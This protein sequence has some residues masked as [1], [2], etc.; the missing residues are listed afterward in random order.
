[1]SLYQAIVAAGVRPS[2]AARLARAIADAVAE[3]QSS[4]FAAVRPSSGFST[5]GGSNDFALHASAP[6]SRYNPNNGQVAPGPAALGV[7]GVAVF[8]GDVVTLGKQYTRGI[9]TKGDMQATGKLS[10]PAVRTAFVSVLNAATFSSQAATI[11]TPIVAQGGLACDGS[12]SFGNNVEFNGRVSVRGD[13]DWNGPRVPGDVSVVRALHWDAA[14]NALYIHRGPIG[15]LNDYGTDHV[16]SVPL[17]TPGPPVVKVGSCT[18]IP[19]LSVDKSG[20]V[21]DLDAATLSSAQLTAV[22]STTT[23][24]YLEAL[25]ASATAKATVSISG[26]SLT[27]ATGV[28]QQEAASTAVQ[29]SSSTAAANVITSLSA[30]LSG[31]AAVT[32]TTTPVTF[33]NSVTAAF[34]G[35]LSAKVQVGTAMLTHVTGVQITTLPYVYDVTTSAASVSVLGGATLNKGSISPVNEVASVST[36]TVLSQVSPV[37]GVVMTTAAMTPGMTSPVNEVSSVATGKALAAVT[38]TSV[39]VLAAATLE[40]GNITPV[41][42]VEKVSSVTA[43]ANP[44][45]ATSSVVQGVSLTLATTSLG[46]RVTG[47]STQSVLATATLNAGTS[48]FITVVTSVTFNTTTCQLTVTTA[49]IQSRGAPSLTTSAANVVS[50]VATTTFQPVTNVTLNSQAS[51]VKLLLSADTLSVVSQVLTQSKSVLGTPHTLKTS[52]VAAVGAISSQEATVVT[53]VVTQPK[54]VVVTNPSFTTGTRQVV[55]DI[56]PTT[57]AVVTEVTTQAKDVL[58]TNPTLDTSPQSISLISGITTSSTSV[59]LSVLT[60]SVAY[61]NSVSA[62]ITGLSAELTSTTTAVDLAA[63]GRYD[64]DLTGVTVSTKSETQ[65]LTYVSSASI[66]VGGPL[67]AAVTALTA[68]TTVGRA[69]THD[70][71]FASL[72]VTTHPTAKTVSPV[73]AVTLSQ[74]TVLIPC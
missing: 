46:G 2:E 59:S 42:S 25:T 57:A 71:T 55:A 38:P 68:T 6:G 62:E 74:T 32:I 36:A 7:D 52:S 15:V 61:V 9:H 34:T 54:D 14:G 51:P 27:Y 41:N 21:V 29:L 43:L 65:A 13:V 72:T 33:V 69:T 26:L 49:V 37:T 48:S 5:P 31:G 58:V 18:V 73:T 70:V 50:S 30:A 28:N 16:D 4:Q 64:V 3:G 20:F 40:G 67:L 53:D 47:T 60:N 11:S 12:A 22:G 23:V 66:S 44:V 35:S 1:M 10:V 56:N 19:V 17:V 63:P 24:S 39:N 45:F 8:G